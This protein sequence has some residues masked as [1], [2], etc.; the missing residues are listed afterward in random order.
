[1]QEQFAEKC[2][3]TPVPHRNVVRR[4]TEKFRETGSMSDAERSGTPSKLNGEKSM[5]LSPP[6]FCLWGAAK[7]AVY[8]HRPRTHEL[9]TAITA[10]LRNISQAAL[11]KVSANKI[12]RV[13]T[14]T[15]LL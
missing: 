12:K 13:Q 1:V 5:D 8:R 15:D 9:K 10:Y 4:L 3:E 2:P 7:S 11:Q 14:C 6:D